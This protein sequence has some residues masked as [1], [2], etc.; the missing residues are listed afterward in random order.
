[1]YYIV[2][3]TYDKKGIDGNARLTVGTRLEASAN[4]IWF[5]GRRVCLLTSQNAYDHFAIDDDGMGRKRFAL[6][7]GIL[8]DVAKMK[9]DYADKVDSIIKDK[10]IS[11]EEKELRISGIRNRAAE[12][13]DAVYEN[14]EWAPFMKKVGSD[15]IWGHRFYN[16]DIQALEAL[17][18][19]L[20][21]IKE[22]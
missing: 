20:N 15:G 19:K 3:K 16:G 21:E 8:K 22:D 10:T 12:F 9:A 18:A 17:D 5:L 14:P 2:C 13:F 7:H 6:T 4:L 1:M 11:N